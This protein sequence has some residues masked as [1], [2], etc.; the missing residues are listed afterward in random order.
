MRKWVA[1]YHCAQILKNVPHCDLATSLTNVDIGSELLPNSKTLGIAWDL[2]NDILCVT[3][4]EFSKATTRRKMASQ[5]DPLG[6]VSPCLLEGKLIL[7][8]VA[9]SGAEW[10]EVISGDIQDCWKKWLKHSELFKEFYIPRNCLPDNCSK[11]AAAYQLHV[12]CDA[13]N[14]AFCCVVNLRC[15]VEEKP[16]INFV[17]GK[18]KLALTHQINWVISRKELEAVKLCCEL[19]LLAKQA[20]RVFA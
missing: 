15:L 2:Q 16:M 7:Q 10:D 14:S 18:S 12:F 1:N 17:L 8:Q 4:K 6:I 5:L 20:L 13:W 19:R 3:C 9:T 11:H